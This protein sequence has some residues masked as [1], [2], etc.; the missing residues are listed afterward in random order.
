MTKREE[1][2]YL[3]GI[4][5]P[6]VTPFTDGGALDEDAFRAQAKFIMNAGVQ[7][8]SPG[9]STGEG[10][11]IHDEERV[12]M[13]EIIKEENDRNIP[14][15]AGI[16]RH[17]TRDALKA[18]LECRKAGASAL[19]VTP[20]QYLG[21]TD[22]DG[23]YRY[24]Q[25]ISDVVQMPVIIYNVVPQNIV[26]PESAYEMLRGI[27]YL[28]GI[29][30]STGGVHSFMAMQQKCG[31]EGMIY[32]ATDELPYTTYEMGADG[33]IA[34]IL[35]LF[36]ELS[37]KIWNLYKQGKAEEGIRL[38]RLVY[39]VWMSIT[40]SQFPRRLKAALDCIG[41]GCGGA[42]APL[43]YAS[44]TEYTQ[45]RNALKPYFEYEKGEK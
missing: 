32:A 37:V 30:Q 7:G 3:S 29:K 21:G 14:I 13:I 4:I 27:E 41:R 31:R 10:C 23:N 11:A 18:G 19:M 33:E 40:G 44:E 12:R 45:I 38:Q 35:G 6:V 42:L 20:I 15:V 43:G 36:P 25:A 8:I 22:M 17:S 34:A 9:G 39:N 5:A 16:I 28:L 2:A 24:Y 1:Y 26:S